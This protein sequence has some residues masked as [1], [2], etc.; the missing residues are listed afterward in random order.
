MYCKKCKGTNLIIYNKSFYSKYNQG[1]FE[2]ITY[3]DKIDLGDRFVFSCRDCGEGS[4]Y[5]LYN[6]SIL[7]KRRSVFEEGNDAWE[8]LEHQVKFRYPK[9]IQEKVVLDL[10]DTLIREVYSK[11]EAEFSMEYGY[12]Q[13]FKIRPHWP[14]FYAYLKKNFKSIEIITA[15]RSDYAKE[16]ADILGFEGK[17]TSRESLGC[18]Q[19]TLMAF[20]REYLKKC[21]DSLV[22]DDK[23]EVIYGEGN[24]IFCNKYDSEDTWLK[25]VIEIIEQRKK[26]SQEYHFP[27]N[28][29]L[30]LSQSGNEGNSLLL[31]MIGKIK[32]E[33][34]DELNKILIKYCPLKGLRGKE[35][36]SYKFDS[37]TIA[38]WVHFSPK[39]D[40]GN[41]KK[42]LSKLGLKF[43]KRFFKKDLSQLYKEGTLRDD[44]IYG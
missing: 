10:D 39:A 19:R 29:S 25:D 33:N 3:V 13:H 35:N 16:V 1:F 44:I 36:I 15:A 4:M 22:F 38:A 37:D 30:T 12:L 28:F 6:N 42:D 26:D 27:K 9:I 43:K 24:F 34:I 14:E 31:E 23:P 2:I 21:D 18:D 8:K 32:L 40:V 17:I 20:E 11:D 5:R 7:A 41:L